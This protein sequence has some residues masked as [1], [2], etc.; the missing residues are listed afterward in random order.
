MFQFIGVSIVR[1]PACL[2]A[3]ISLCSLMAKA[4]VF[5][6]TNPV[7]GNFNT[8]GNWTLVSGATAAPPN[9]GDEAR[10]NEAASYTVTFL[11]NEAS[12]FLNVTVGAVTFRSNGTDRTYTLTTG[13]ADAA[14]LTGTLT[15][16]VVNDPL[17]LTIGDDLT[18]NS[19]GT[20]NVD[21]GSDVNV[22]D[23]VNVGTNSGGGTV[24]VSGTGSSIDFGGAVNLGV[25][26]GVGTLRLENGS[27]DNTVRGLLQLIGGSGVAGSTG[28]LDVFSG[29][30]L[31]T[32]SII[33]GNSASSSLVQTAEL[34]VDG[35]GSDVEML[36]A[37]TL[38]VGDD[39]NPNIVANLIVG[40]SGTFNTGTG[41]IL[42]RNSGTI[43]VNLLGT[44]NANGNVTID[45]GTL[46][47]ND[48]TADFNL[49]SGLSLLAQ[50]DAQFNFTDDYTINNNTTWTL[51]SGA[52]YNTAGTSADIRIGVTTSGTLIVED[53]GSTLNLGTG[54]S[55]F[56][57]IGFLGGTGTL[58]VRDSA[59]ATLGDVHIAPEG[60][61]G[62][63]GVLNIEDGAQ[64]T[65]NNI[66]VASP[67]FDSNSGTMNIGGIIGTATL[68]QNGASF[69]SVGGNTGSGTINI[70][71][72]G[73]LNTGIATAIS[74]TGLINITGGILDL[75]GDLTIE[76]GEVRRQSG[77]LFLQPS[78]NVIVRS[79]G[80]LEITGNFSINTDVELTVRSGSTYSSTGNTN[81]GEVSNATFVVENAV[82]NIGGDSSW[83]SGGG[84]ANVTFR[85]FSQATLG[86]VRL[87][88][89]GASTSVVSVESGSNVTMTSLQIANNS[90]AGS[91]AT[92]TVRDPFTSV[93]VTTSA[94]VLNIGQGVNGTATL[95]V[96]DGATFNSTALISL[97]PTGTINLDAGSMVV[98]S[99]SDAGGTFNYLGGSLSMN[100]DFT[101]GFAGLLH[102]NSLTLDSNDT[103]A[104]N[105]TATI[106]PLA[107]LTIDGGTFSAGEFVNNG[108]LQFNR[109][110][111]RITGGAGMTIGAGGPLGSTA[112]FGASQRFEVTN[113]LTVDGGATL[114]IDSNAEVEAGTLSNSGHV[115]LEGAAAVLGGTT[116]SNSGL[117]RGEGIIS[118]GVTN[119]AGGEIRAQSGKTLT[120]S[121]ANGAN[122][123]AIN[124][125]GGTL[126]FA[127]QLTNGATGDITGRG[128]LSVG[129]AGL[130]N[131]GDIA[132]SGGS[133]DVF[134]D[135]DNQGAGRVIISGNSDV[136]FWDD[137]SHSGALFNVAAGSSATF[138][139]D[140]G[141]GITGGGDVFFEDD[142]TPGSSPGLESFGGN[143]HFGAL[144][145]LQL[146]LGGTAQG[147]QYDALA[148]AGD[149]TLAGTLD[150]SLVDDFTLSLGDS[151]EIIDIT[152][153]R[154]GTF[155]GLAEGATVG[156]FTGHD[157]LISYA[158]GDGNDV[159]LF[160]PG[161]PGD[162]NFDGTV[163]AADYIVWRKNGLS[164]EEYG[165][166][167]AHFGE[168]VGGGSAA[169]QSGVP[170]PAAVA[171]VVVCVM[172]VTLLRGRRQTSVSP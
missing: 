12:D 122:S 55:S 69:L 158:G 45:G 59:A 85:D 74:S 118:A 1:W 102:T 60:I 155:N 147:S 88:S 79:N 47:R 141:F 52:D 14:I 82:A 143:V 23:V 126:E 93:S 113:T 43:V 13:A 83:G 98:N 73:R 171:F 10:F 67:G 26:G 121:G 127:Q 166:W 58:T 68:T 22:G 161:L 172:S 86:V 156:N 100:N 49:G 41:A 169:S 154:S 157:L 152:G 57:F 72:G 164:P 105:N 21:F 90:A 70:S 3:A 84:T 112:T 66:F 103:I 15:L 132:L 53:S 131:Q 104:T 78:S 95:N 19:G 46:V 30:T 54:P 108:T 120:L 167:S 149:A 33:V 39:T 111:L 123:G 24:R 81:I 163:D 129:G 36:G 138:F 18:V 27:T 34:T 106:D 139:G 40:N 16:G 32:S 48:S 162:F 37:S 28:L 142:I 62:T 165:V 117:L 146:E 31:D 63:T 75:N 145:N 87:A 136:T 17:G 119:N 114:V 56:S 128:T 76:G 125:Q 64:V 8:A 92:L 51:Q 71:S 137:V 9:A 35:P 97:R 91:S 38:T 110:S 65:A 140:A 144:A 153:A 170:E 148:I 11:N 89:S 116:V 101:L 42:V 4:D 61:S 2:V 94:Q 77:Q 150:V 7:N 124:L 5:E 80:E 168:S 50:N 133:T 20:L 159:A 130:S 107:T 115:V 96:L 99:I 134:G 135:V 29:S 44:F 109:G 6:W 25:S 151:F 160:V